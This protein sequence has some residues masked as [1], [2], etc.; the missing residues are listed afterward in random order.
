MEGRGVDAEEADRPVCWFK[1][2]VI[3]EIYILLLL[4]LLHII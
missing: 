1:Q 2:N 4:F 3:R